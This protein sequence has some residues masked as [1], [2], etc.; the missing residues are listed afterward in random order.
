MDSPSKIGHVIAIGMRCGK[1]WFSQV[2]VPLTALLSWLLLNRSTWA[3]DAMGSGLG[4]RPTLDQ[5]STAFSYSN[6]PNHAAG[7]NENPLWIYV[8]IVTWSKVSPIQ[9][10]W[11]M[12]HRHGSWRIRSKEISAKQWL[13]VVAAPD[14]LVVFCRTFGEILAMKVRSHRFQCL[15]SVRTWKS[16]ENRWLPYRNIIE[17]T[18]LLDLWEVFTELVQLGWFSSGSLNMEVYELKSAKRPTE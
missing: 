6:C 16:D 11:I 7:T 2:N 12:T 9:M 4:P 3:L 1:P 15:E 5:L 8:N 10:T 17:S 13:A 18:K 14:L